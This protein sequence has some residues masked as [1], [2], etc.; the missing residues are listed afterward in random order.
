MN[1]HG[2]RSVM[3]LCI[4]I[5]NVLIS[6]PLAIYFGGVGAAIG[7]AIG[8]LLGQILFMNWFYY[9]K[10]NLNIPK[11][12]KEIGCLFIKSLPVVLV[13]MLSTKMFSN[14][15][16]M[17]L[18]IEIIVGVEIGIPYYYFVILNPYEKGLVL[19][20]VKKVIK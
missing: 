13:F 7:T 6:I 11:Y 8:N 16:W 2:I 12:W 14:W 20:S 18:C 17:H 5:L 15:S 3:Y 9:K 1:K 19:S 4:A 10:I